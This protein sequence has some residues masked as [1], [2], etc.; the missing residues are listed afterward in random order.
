MAALSCTGENLCEDL[1]EGTQCFA[2]NADLV[3]LPKI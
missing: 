3:M 2:V 1:K